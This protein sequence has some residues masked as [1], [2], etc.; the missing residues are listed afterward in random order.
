[1]VG[2]TKSI[3][4]VSAE[5]DSPV[6]VQS[7]PL[8]GNTVFLK[9]DCDYKNRADKAYF[10]YSLDGNHWTRI[11]KP[12]QMSYTLPHFMGYRFTLFNYATKTEGGFVDFDY[13]RISNKI[14]AVP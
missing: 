4:M 14:A 7:V 12:L 3:V 9:V 5:S 8:T 6:E 1:M 10:F 11:G 13:F 2:N